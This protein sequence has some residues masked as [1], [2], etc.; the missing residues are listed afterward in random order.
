MKIEKI[1]KSADNALNLSNTKEQVNRIRVIVPNPKYREYAAQAY[2]R[3]HPERL[4]AQRYLTVFDA[5]F[6]MGRSASAST[7]Y[8]SVWIHGKDGAYRSGRGNAGGYGYHKES[9]AM[10][11]AL[12]AA[13]FRFKES[14]GGSGEQAM[15]LA[16]LT[17]ARAI[18]W[19]NG[20]LV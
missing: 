1:G 14:W 19:N 9:A 3:A 13:G 10:E 15:N 12:A 4:A 11:S 16:A 20:G 8:C 7:V 2:Y 18:G 5:R 17:V 6:Y